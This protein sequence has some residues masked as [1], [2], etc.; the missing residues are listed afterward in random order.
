MNWLTRWLPRGL[1]SEHR[2]RRDAWR[3]L[4]TVGLDTPLSA[5]RSIV[6]DLET[7]GLHPRRDRILAIGAVAVTGRS[8][9]LG[10]GFS[11]V[12]RQPFSGSRRNVVVHGITPGQQAQG[13]HPRDAV[14][15]FLEYAGAAPLVAFHAGFDQA[16]LQRA[17]RRRLRTGLR[18][19]FLD[20]AWLLPALVPDQ[21][22]H[23]RGLDDWL[24]R[25]GIAVHGRHTAMGDAMA[26]AELYLLALALAANRASTL[27]DLLR[28]AEAEAHRAMH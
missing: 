16:F 19:R 12:L 27:G 3:S 9:G 25:H 14:L 24:Q 28:L 1:D 26:T 21:P 10:E 11:A 20:L 4:P 7:T 17:V 5:L 15:E 18:N 6:V 22:P 23:R 8:L 13:Q 2:Q